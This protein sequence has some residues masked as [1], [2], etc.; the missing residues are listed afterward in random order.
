M[1]LLKENC[2]QVFQTIKKINVYVQYYQFKTYYTNTNRNAFLNSNCAQ[3]SDH[4]TFFN[5]KI[6]NKLKNA[7]SSCYLQ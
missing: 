5:N 1:H 7:M 6:N 4:R 2:Y 3:E